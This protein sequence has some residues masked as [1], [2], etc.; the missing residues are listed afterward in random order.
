MCNDPVAQ[1]GAVFTTLHCS[2]EQKEHVILNI[3]LFTFTKGRPA[4]CY[5]QSEHL[6]G[7]NTEQSRGKLIWPR[8]RSGQCPGYNRAAGKLLA[9][10]RL[11]LQRT[12]PASKHPHVSDSDTHAPTSASKR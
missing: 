7:S 8:K 12:S 11:S 4:V 10:A 5:S 3:L 9:Q 2:T 1:V 6:T